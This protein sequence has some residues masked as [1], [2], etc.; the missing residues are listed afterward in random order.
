MVRISWC[1]VPSVSA[2]VT[3]RVFWPSA[4]LTGRFTAMDGCC[5]RFSCRQSSTPLAV[6][7]TWR[8]PVP[9]CTTAANVIVS[10]S[11]RAWFAGVEIVIRNAAE[12]LTDDSGGTAATTGGGAGEATAGD[13]VGARGGSAD[14]RLGCRGSGAAGAAAGGAGTG[15]GTGAARPGGRGRRDR[16]GGHRGRGPVVEEHPAFLAADA[17][18]V[19]GSDDQRVSPRHELHGHAER[20]VLARRAGLLLPRDLGAVE[21]DRDPQR[22][23]AARHLAGEGDPLRGHATLVLRVGERHRQRRRRGLVERDRLEGEPGQI[24]AVGPHELLDGRRV[25]ERELEPPRLRRGGEEA[26][27]EHLHDAEGLEHA[28]RHGR[29]WPRPGRG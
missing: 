14:G 11:T 22:A 29:S 16:G 15:A 12:G 21:R 3:T 23:G 17:G 19:R 27:L 1:I 4:S 24:V 28:G 26:R 2:A 10:C 9:P 13:G 5:V 25:P 18:A 20:H 6:T 8:T 7:R